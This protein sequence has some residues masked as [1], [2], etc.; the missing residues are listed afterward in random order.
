MI[1]LEVNHFLCY[2]FYRG[3]FMFFF[4]FNDNYTAIIGDIIDSRKSEYRKEVQKKLKTVLEEINE[5]YFDYI[6]SKFMI[7]L[8]DEF[9]GLLKDRR[10]IIKI[11]SDIEIKMYPIQ[12]RFGVGIGA[13]NTDINFNN[14]IEIDGPAY[15][16]ARK[17]INIL[18]NKKKQYE[19]S[20][21]N[22]MICSGDE[23]EEIDY[24]I[25]SILSLC[26]ALKENWTDRQV[27]IISAYVKC[28][29]NQ[30]KTSK[31]LNIGQSSVSK[32]LKNSN[33]FTYRTAIEKVN[34]FLS[35]ERNQI[36]D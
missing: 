34:D 31:K 19:G 28:N 17:M 14:S 16:R 24:L 15:N 1:H 5:T 32:A 11:I 22:I 25:N 9:Q 23:N 18:N 3:D 36:D 12:I 10:M 30:H 8:G 2:Y 6:A 13:I 35:E 29:Q 33:Y 7:T 27:E 20:Y 4:Y 21:A 26:G